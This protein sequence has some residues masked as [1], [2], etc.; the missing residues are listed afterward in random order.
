MNRKLSELLNFLFFF[1][2]FT[3]CDKISKCDKHSEAGSV[4]VMQ[5]EDLRPLQFGIA[6]I[7]VECK[8]RRFESMSQPELDE[9]LQKE[10]NRVNVIL[11][12]KGVYLVDGHHMSRALL[13]ADVS[14]KHKKVYCNVVDNLV[15]LDTDDFWDRLLID[16]RIWLYDEKGFCPLAPEHLPRRL[17]KMLDDPFRTL[18]WLVQHAGGFLKSGIDFEDFQWT[19]FF[20][21]NVDIKSNSLV[22][23]SSKYD[24]SHIY[25]YTNA[26]SWKWCQ[27]RPNSK[28]CMPDQ[29]QFLERVLP[30]ALELAASEE[31][32]HLPGYGDGNVDPPK[33]GNYSAL[34]FVNDAKAKLRGNF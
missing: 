23:L 19:N 24:L 28:R 18:A 27:V 33:C 30:L 26:T 1:V 15:H 16:N 22:K 13:D 10:K 2:F 5:V 4:C 14:D 3:S 7:E 20:R 11:G 25:Q 29:L 21:Q 8:R 12:R 6:G 17:S 32:S 34:L 9:Y 31:A